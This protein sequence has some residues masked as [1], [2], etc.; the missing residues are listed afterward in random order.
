MLNEPQHTISPI[1]SNNLQLSK[2]RSNKIEFSLAA[3][4]L[5]NIYAAIC[6]SNCERVSVSLFDCVMFA[7]SA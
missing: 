5:E 2:D 3:Y 7:Y 1:H 6:K 4:K